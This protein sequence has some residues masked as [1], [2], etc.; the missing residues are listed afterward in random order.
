MSFLHNKHNYKYLADKATP[1][2]EERTY[3]GAAAQEDIRKEM[4]KRLTKNNKTYTK[5]LQRIRT[6]LRTTS[7]AHLYNFE[8]EVYQHDISGLFGPLYV[9][10]WKDSWNDLSKAYTGI[11]LEIIIIRFLFRGV[12]KHSD[13]RKEHGDFQKGF[14]IFL[15]E[16]SNKKLSDLKDS[17]T[18]SIYIVKCRIIFGE[19]TDYFSYFNKAHFGEGDFD[20][21][22]VKIFN[23][24]LTQNKELIW[25]L[26][27]YYN[28]LVDN[29]KSSP[30]EGYDPRL[31]EIAL[32]LRS[33]ETINRVLSINLK[34]TGIQGSYNHF[35]NHNSSQEEIV[36]FDDL[37]LVSG[38][39]NPRSFYAEINNKN[40]LLK[41]HGKGAA[42]LES[43]INWFNKKGFNEYEYMNIDYDSVN[44]LQLPYVYELNQPLK[45]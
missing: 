13:D 2:I 16:N 8:T 6:F 43:A 37:C 36:S 7:Y 45:S 34:L 33:V 40:G 4:I 38:R 1:I 25:L 12:E 21:F 18:I 23:S 31:G 27:Q 32:V 9:K 17:I 14:K 3:K 29:E 10:K 28:H 35:E 24:Q 15:D 22:K 41:M 39:K 11:D 44:L 20:Y 26:K 30:S 19:Y 5:Y 42:T